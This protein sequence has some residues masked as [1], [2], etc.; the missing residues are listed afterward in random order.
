MIITTKQLKGMIK[1]GLRQHLDD[2]EI[3]LDHQWNEEKTGYYAV[4]DST[5]GP[6]GYE[7]YITNKSY[8]TFETG[9]S[10]TLDGAYDEEGG[11][12]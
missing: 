4:I 9:E 5:T 7:W 2:T 8:E 12:S 11:D 10:P 6:R 3:S 1:E